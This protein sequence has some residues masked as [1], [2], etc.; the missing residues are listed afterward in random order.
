MTRLREDVHDMTGFP[1]L[2]QAADDI[3]HGIRQMRRAPAVAAVLIATLALGIGADSAIFSVLNAVLLKPF[4]GR[5]DT[6]SSV[7]ALVT[8]P[9]SFNSREVPRESVT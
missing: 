9:V 7:T 4:R 3:V 5:Q 2:E 1:R 8:P 6:A